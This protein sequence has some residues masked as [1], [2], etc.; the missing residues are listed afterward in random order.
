MW[1]NMNMNTSYCYL[2]E[3]HQVE[4]IW[5]QNILWTL[6]QM[7]LMHIIEYVLHFNWFRNIYKLVVQQVASLQLQ[8]H[9]FDLVLKFLSMCLY[10]FP[11]GSQV[12]STFKNHASRWLG[13]ANLPLRASLCACWP[14]INWLSHLGY[15]PALCHVL[16]YRRWRSSEEPLWQP[17]T[18]VSSSR[19]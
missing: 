5:C 11:P 1:P 12:S 8:D 17:R 18:F 3:M 13:Y 15:I 7:S 14:L 6:S 16:F 10:E 2:S 9:W 19:I 4:A